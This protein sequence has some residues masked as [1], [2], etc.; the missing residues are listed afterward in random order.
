MGDP[1]PSQQGTNLEG[2]MK[3][4]FCG[5]RGYFPHIA[6]SAVS[7]AENNRA[8]SLDVHILTCDRD[9][10]GEEL[11]RS[12]LARYENVRFIV[13]I[14]DDV[15]IKTFFVDGFMTKECYL[16]FIAPELLPRE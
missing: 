6:A 4:L 15:H 9:A 10:L 11:L 8:S 3:I 14:V 13:H 5:N 2:P 16:R 1:G 12:S 7:L